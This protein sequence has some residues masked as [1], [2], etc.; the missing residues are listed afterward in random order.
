MG[1]A[2]CFA[3]P[4]G[5]PKGAACQKP[6]RRSMASRPHNIDRLRGG[7][8]RDSRADDPF[9]VPR[10]S[11]AAATAAHAAARSR[12]RRLVD[13]R[14]VLPVR[15][16]FCGARPKHWHL[17]RHL[18]RHAHARR[19]TDH[20]DLPADAAA[21]LAEMSDS[22]LAAVLP[23][24]LARP[25]GRRPPAAPGSRPTRHSPFCRSCPFSRCFVSLRPLQGR[26]AE[27]AVQLAASSP[28]SRRL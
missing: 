20:T 17:D 22:S 21:D 2:G 5:P 26:E 4:A 12:R 11:S 27:A 16:L 9:R 18:D 7:W 14:V 23:C 25:M 28:H 6:R 13:L 19:T 1:T 8:R 15:T 3:S 24:L 10:Q